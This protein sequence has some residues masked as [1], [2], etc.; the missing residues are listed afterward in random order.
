MTAK[1]SGKK[2]GFF[3]TLNIV[4][5]LLEASST[6]FKSKTLRFI[7]I[8][9][10]AYSLISNKI[11]EEM[12]NF[13]EQVK[14]VIITSSFVIMAIIFLLIGGTMYLEKLYPKLTN[15]L[16]FMVVGLGFLFLGIIYNLIKK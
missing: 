6:V 4:K 14:R 11:D 2:T 16:N 12:T 7:K 8:T 15:G 1:K 3:E 5:E 10:K 9:T 13:K